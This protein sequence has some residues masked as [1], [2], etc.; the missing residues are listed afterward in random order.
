MEFFRDS[1][2]RWPLLITGLLLLAESAVQAASPLALRHAVNSVGTHDLATA[3]LASI[4]F[5]VSL[6]MARALRGGLS[7]TYTKIVLAFRA[8]VSQRI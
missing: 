7:Y 6:G 3:G 2:R 5:A 4:V 8:D 1:K